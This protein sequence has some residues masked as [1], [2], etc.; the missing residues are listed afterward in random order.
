MRVASQI[1]YKETQWARTDCYVVI[2]KFVKEF[3]TFVHII[4]DY[5]EVK[6]RA[7]ERYKIQFFDA[8]CH[9]KKNLPRNTIKLEKDS[10]LKE[11]S[12]E[13]AIKADSEESEKSEEEDTADLNFIRFHGYPQRTITKPKKNAPLEV[14]CPCRCKSQKL[15]WVCSACKDPVFFDFSNHLYCKCGA[16]EKRRADYW[17]GDA[18]HGDAYVPH[19]EHVF[20]GIKCEEI[21]IILM[22]E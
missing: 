14:A 6:I 3:D 8:A 22:G 12:T 5:E 1:F 9:S 2:Q 15:N 10:E 11:P 17:C 19:S 4:G 21:N 18:R 20:R 16:H 13:K 7:G